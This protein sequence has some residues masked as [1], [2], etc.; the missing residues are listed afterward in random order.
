MSRYRTETQPCSAVTYQFIS[1][2]PGGTCLFHHKW[3]QVEPQLSKPPVVY[4]ARSSQK[5]AS[6]RWQGGH[7]RERRRERRRKEDGWVC[8]KEKVEHDEHKYHIL[9]RT[10]W[11]CHI[12]SKCV[13]CGGSALLG[14]CVLKTVSFNK[15]SENVQCSRQPIEKH[16]SCPTSSVYSCI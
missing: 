15:E 13:D 2:P 9:K 7:E 3:N 16:T 4:S 6:S 1:L 5:T 14:N 12:E 11:N 8:L 10:C